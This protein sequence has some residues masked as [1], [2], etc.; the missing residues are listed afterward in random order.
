MILW[1]E[2]VLTFHLKLLVI[3][4]LTLGDGIHHWGFWAPGPYLLV[5]GISYSLGQGR[6]LTQWKSAWGFIEHLLCAGLC[7]RPV[8]TGAVRSERCLKLRLRLLHS[9]GNSQ[10]N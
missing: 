2:S 5:Q 1:V 9:K 10:Q 3:S 7:A 8:K 4:N 6:A